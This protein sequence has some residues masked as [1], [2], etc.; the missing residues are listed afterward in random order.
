MKWM[1][2]FILIAL[3]AVLGCTP[4]PKAPEQGDPDIQK[5]DAPTFDEAMA[6]YETGTWLDDYSEALRQ[7]K[8]MNR[9]VLVDYTGSD[10]CSWCMKLD[11]EVF[12]QSAFIDYA[13]SSLILVKVDFPRRKSQTPEQQATNEK[14]MNQYG[15]QGFPTIILLSAEGKELNRTGYQPGGAEAYVKHLQGLLATA[16]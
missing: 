16:K 9:P 8:E 3:I 1:V 2:L 7:A 4:A 12:S 11:K 15:V 14:L 5:E 13:K 6:K 10:W